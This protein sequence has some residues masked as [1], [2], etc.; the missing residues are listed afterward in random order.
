MKHMKRRFSA[1][2]A[3]LLVLALATGALAEALPAPAELF[4]R[5]WYNISII[6]NLPDSAAD[7]ADDL[8]SYYNY[9][10]VAAHQDAAANAVLGGDG[11]I[12]AAVKEAL[13]DTSLNDPSVEQLRIFYE[14]AMD[15]ETRKKGDGLME[16]QPY[17]SAVAN[18]ETLEQL[19]A[20]IL[21]EDFPFSPFVEL[22]VANDYVTGTNCVN[23][24]ANLAFSDEPA[25][26]DP[27]TD[28]MDWQV[29]LMAMGEKYQS[30]TIAYMM[31][32]QDQVAAG[33]A[34]SSVVDTERNWAVYAD[35]ATHYTAK[36]YG[37]YA[38]DTKSMTLNDLEI[39]CPHFPLKETLAKFGKD[40]SE[41]FV[42]I[43]PE[44]LAAL[45]AFWTEENLNA[46]RELIVAK[47]MMECLPYLDRTKY[48]EQLAVLGSDP[49]TPEANAWKVCTDTKT[50]SHL[51]AKLY[52]ERGL[53][54]RAKE[55]LTAMAK[56]LVD[57]LG[58]L[59]SETKW[60]S[61]DARARA[62]AKTQSMKLNILEPEGGYQDFSTLSLL[63]TEEGG[64]LLTNYLR[65]KAW[66]NEQ[67]N[68]LLGTPGL[69]RLTWVAMSPVMTNAFYDP[70]SNSI[71][72]LPG[73]L[74]GGKYTDDI[75]EIKLIGAVGT[76]IGH[77]IS[78]GFDFYGS[79]FDADAAPNPLYTEADE[80]AFLALVQ[81]VVD[82]YS[83]I[84]VL[85]G[86]YEDGNMLKAEAV[87]D[88]VGMKVA[89]TYARSLGYTDLEPV[90][91]ADAEFYAQTSDQN[92]AMVLMKIDTHPAQYLRVNVN[93][94]MMDEFYET[95]DVKESNNMYIAPESRLRIWGPDVK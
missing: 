33:S 44:W 27:P 42:V 77:E 8:Y 41:R 92:T 95:F 47:V 7:A 75:S 22:V 63:K 17:L 73:Y 28:V 55:R 25:T 58:G 76:A 70:A 68:A 88:L 31:G 9:D 82:Y 34:A 1:L 24:G 43:A 2:L 3:L 21:S 14:Q 30:L 5:P 67:D 48:N 69:S 39:L 52:T 87:A 45:D 85:P 81:K 72:I 94:Q 50:F 59:I 15:T 86:L 20:A 11:E 16:L 32:G 62:L 49:E 64:T 84:E 80:T 35:S 51:A 54:A 60:I 29:K 71:N 12:R 93:A 6:G 37:A 90:F 74:T 18:A 56:G 36:E 4:G 23:I 46:L 19:N 10:F 78:H 89:L 79:Q 91:R 65:I 57:T 26:Y 38:E 83:T 13:A 40:K 66:W 61:E 53:G